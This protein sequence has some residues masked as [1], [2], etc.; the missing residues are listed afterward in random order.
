MEAIY[1]PKWAKDGLM[2]QTSRWSSIS[3]GE[4]FH[5]N[6]LPKG[7]STPRWAKLS[8]LCPQDWLKGLRLIIN[9]NQSRMLIFA[10]INLIFFC[11]LLP[12]A[13]S[14]K[15]GFLFEPHPLSAITDLGSKI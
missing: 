14:T 7:K 4:C 11:N 15:Q 10:N 1:G 13:I 5:A 2:I 3:D 12:L 8:M 6:K 9:L